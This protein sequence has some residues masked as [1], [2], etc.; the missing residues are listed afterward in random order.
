MRTS[1]VESACAFCGG[2][3]FVKLSHPPYVD[4]ISGTQT[5]SLS[6]L[7]VPCTCRLHGVV[8]VDDPRETKSEKPGGDELRGDS[9]DH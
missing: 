4:P 3:G 7:F 5:P 2:S 8:E 6:G 9:P 1:A